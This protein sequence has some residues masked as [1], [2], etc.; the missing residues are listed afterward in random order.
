MRPAKDGRVIAREQALTEAV[1]QITR[2]KLPA[3]QEVRV[4]LE[5][6]QRLAGLDL[7]NG[8]KVWV[9]RYLL[10]HL[11]F[12]S[13]LRAGEIA[14]LQVGDF[15]W[16]LR[17]SRLSVRGKI[18]RRPRAVH[19]GPQLAGHI[20]AYLRVRRH[21]WGK[22]T[23]LDDLLLPGRAG[24]PYSTAALDFSFR[25]AVLAARLSWACSLRNA[26]H[27]YSAYLLAKTNDLAYVQRQMGHA[28][29]GMTVLYRD[30]APLIDCDLVQDL[31]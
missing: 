20:Q 9:V 15:H 18:G 23:G 3:L 24:R 30:V 1:Y 14:G 19:L 29:Q 22:E 2:D 6:C 17:G 21:A 16:S 27:F 8:R 13:G 28:N 31:F 10:A 11:A 26:R 7:A 12:A 25:K 4:L 5:N